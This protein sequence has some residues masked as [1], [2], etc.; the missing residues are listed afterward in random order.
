[1]AYNFTFQG[2]AS[3]P[4][5]H[6]VEKFLMFFVVGGEEIPLHQMVS[7]GLVWRDAGYSG[8]YLTNHNVAKIFMSYQG[9]GIEKRY[10]SLYFKMLDKTSAKVEITPFS[11]RTH[12]HFKGTVSFL[13]KREVLALLDEES[14]SYF[15]AKRLRIPPKEVLRTIIKV[16][17]SELL[18]GVR[19]IRVGRKRRALA[20]DTKDTVDLF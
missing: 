3:K 13:T 19:K 12:Y 16:D 1:M 4:S 9:F 8:K 2:G 14:D 18:K 10:T 6:T 11:G 17:K 5:D 7:E 15:W 20:G